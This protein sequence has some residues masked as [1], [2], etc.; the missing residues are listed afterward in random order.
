M[1]DNPALLYS[2][3]RL[4][5][6][7]FQIYSCT[8][9][10]IIFISAEREA[11][12]ETAKG[13]KNT[14]DHQEI[15][16]STTMPVSLQPSTQNTKLVCAKASSDCP[17]P[18]GRKLLRAERTVPKTTSSVTEPAN[19]VLT[20]PSPPPERQIIQAKR[21]EARTARSATNT[22][23]IKPTQRT[24]VSTPVQTPVASPVTTPLVSPVST[25]VLTPGPS[26]VHFP[27]PAPVSTPISFTFKKH[28]VPDAKPTHSPIPNTVPF[29]VPTLLVGGAK[30]K[31][32]PIPFTVSSM[33]PT[34]ISKP[35]PF[36]TPLPSP[37]TLTTGIQSVIPSTSGTFALTTP[38]PHV[39]I[40][41]EETAMD[42]DIDVLVFSDVSFIFN[43]STIN[44]IY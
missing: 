6:N 42:V 5:L 41:N 4:G 18:S 39:A 19:T 21:G 37:L 30:P 44:V 10:P 14:E 34:G 17:P 23:S 40:M 25:P 36:P 7:S 31:L 16:I 13:A 26:S 24:A 1:I 35:V 29:P 38:P 27:V 20:R 28:V 33:A 15:P 12:S 2:K 22:S 3:R 9:F 8:Y 43:I 11:A 32:S